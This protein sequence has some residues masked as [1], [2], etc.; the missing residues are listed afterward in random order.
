MPDIEIDFCYFININHT[1]VLR[2]IHTLAKNSTMPSREG[3]C[4]GGCFLLMGTVLIGA[5]VGSW[6]Q[7]EEY[8]NDR[9]Q[10]HTFNVEDFNYTSTSTYGIRECHECHNAQGFQPCSVMI[11]NNL[12]GTCNMA[13]QNP[14]RCSGYEGR[15]RTYTWTDE[16]HVVHN[17]RYRGRGSGG[18]NYNQ[19]CT[20]VPFTRYNITVELESVEDGVVQ[21]DV[22][23]I[24]CDAP[25]HAE[26]CLQNAQ[27][28][29]IV[30]DI[31]TLTVDTENNEILTGAYECENP[32]MVIG[33]YAVGV[34]FFLF[35][36][37]VMTCASQ[38]DYQQ[39]TYYF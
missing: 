6:H 10:D 37:L 31:V 33:L 13:I 35:G 12:T 8:C 23:N 25:L 20:V 17:D 11:E 28:K 36:V 3:C 16:H 5:G 4:F 30:G 26:E 38:I 1:Q 19:R 39:E 2:R 9:Y 32:N 18:R 27:M 21:E 7:H 29:Y 14:P 24:L 15:S 34:I 22:V